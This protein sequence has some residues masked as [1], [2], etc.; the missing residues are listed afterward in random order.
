MPFV[1][2]APIGVPRSQLRPLD[3][4]AHRWARAQL[5]CMLLSAHAS[6]ELGS[7]LMRRRRGGHAGLGEGLGRN[8]A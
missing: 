2:E 6:T 7:G 3:R 4:A 5:S 8:T 1:Q